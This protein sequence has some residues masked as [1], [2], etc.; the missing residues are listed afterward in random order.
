[1][2]I[3]ILY[4]VLTLWVLIPPESLQEICL[5]IWYRK[6]NIHQWKYISN[7]NLQ[8]LR[9]LSSLWIQRF[10]CL[11][12][13]NVALSRTVPTCFTLSICCRVLIYYKVKEC[14]QQGASVHS[15]LCM[16]S[17]TNSCYAVRQMHLNL[18]RE[19]T[20][21][22]SIWRPLKN[23]SLKYSTKIFTII[24]KVKE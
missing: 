21:P 8:I 19:R 16:F 2:Q 6:D 1:M 18:L 9:T 24:C 7:L 5:P 10:H 11:H 17:W 23:H 14:M 15:K 12:V 13:W 22:D 3:S 4:S 20:Y